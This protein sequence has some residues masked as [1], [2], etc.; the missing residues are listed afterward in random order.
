MQLEDR[1]IIRRSLDRD[2]PFGRLHVSWA[3]FRPALVSENRL[4]RL[5]VQRC[6][7][8][9]NQ[10]LEH[11]LHA[12]ANREDQIS[13]VLHLI[14]GEVIAKSAAFLFLK[15]ERE[16]Q[17]GAVNPT[18]TDL[19]QSPYSPQLGQGLCDLREAGSVGDGGETV[20]FLGEPDACLARLTGDVFMA[21]Q[22]HLRGERWMPADLDGDMPP[23]TVENME[24]IVVHIGLLPL[25]VIVRL[26]VPYRCLGP[27]N[28]NQ[29][30]TFGDRCLGQVLIGHVMLALPRGAVDDWN[31]VRFGIAAHAPAEPAGQPHQMGVVQ[32]FVRARERPPP[33]TEAAGTMSHAEVGIQNDAIHAIIPAAQQLLI[34]RAQSVCHGSLAQGDTEHQRLSDMNKPTRASRCPVGLAFDAGELPHRGHFSPAGSG[35]KR[36]LLQAQPSVPTT[37]R[38]LPPGS[39]DPEDAEGSPRSCPCSPFTTMPTRVPPRT[40]AIG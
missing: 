16:A 11:L 35:E 15:V 26:Y 9:I 6:P 19:A 31:V 18:L 37:V 28:Q 12:P 36:R 14:V 39:L 34:E 38:H 21:V 5:Q 17:T 3:V 29:E 2:F 30:Q 27:T 13:A 22:D 7:A 10:G 25:K 20:C 4:Y 24:R 33:H 1:Q 8:A 40:A 32:G 23:V